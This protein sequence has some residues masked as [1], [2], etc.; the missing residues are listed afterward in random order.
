MILAAGT[1]P[2][3]KDAGDRLVWKAFRACDLVHL[4]VSNDELRKGFMSGMYAL[5]GR[6]ATWYRA[7]PVHF[8]TYVW[9][10]AETVLR[11]L[12]EGI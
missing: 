6:K 11:R 2:P 5:Q 7:S 3:D 9:A 10:F 1:L 8:T 4:R 12:L